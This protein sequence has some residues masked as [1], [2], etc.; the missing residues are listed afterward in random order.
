VSSYGVRVKIA[1]ADGPLVVSPTWTDI[2][3]LAGARV[4]TIEIDRGRPSE[5]AKTDTG[6]ARVSGVDL[7][8]LFD[9][10]NLTST[11]AGNILPRKQAMIELRDPVLNTWHTIFRG[12]VSDWHYVLDITRQFLRFDLELVD[13]FEFL[14]KAELQPGEA[15][16]SVPAG[17]E[18]NVFYEDT[19]GTVSDRID[20][21]LADVGWPAG[22]TEIFTGNVRVREKVYA[23]GTSAL[24]AL[25]D[26]A[27]AEFPGAANLYVSKSGILTFHGRFAR[28]NPQVAAYNINERNVGDPSLTSVDPTAVPLAALGFTSGADNII[29]SCLSYPQEIAAADLAAQLVTDTASITAYGLHAESFSDLQTSYDI[30]NGVTANDAA[31][32][33]GTYYVE[34]MAE[35]R[36]RVNQMVFRTKGVSD[37]LSGPLWIQMTLCEISDLLNLTTA[38]PGGGGFADVPFF[39]EGLHYSITPLNGEVSDVTLTCDVSPSAYFAVN[40]FTARPHAN[41]FARPGTVV[42]S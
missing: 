28:F 18:G 25:F 21:I 5:L 40:P 33:F 7:D 35:P 37:P 9:P 12:F 32:L 26:A 3:P 14:S 31:K 23:P 15:G 29:N 8:G 20:A 30:A 2:V 1:F 34:N 17:S 27:D 42:I 24:A 39:V 19:A 36:P 6:T 10:T 41:A 38:H 13:A 11:Y 4:Q 16:N 22:L